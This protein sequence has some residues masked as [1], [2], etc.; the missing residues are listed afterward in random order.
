MED[1]VTYLAENKMSH[2]GK[3]HVKT[4]SVATM[5]WYLQQ[6]QVFLKYIHF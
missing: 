1:E 5:I 3:I 2:G 4:G 6:V